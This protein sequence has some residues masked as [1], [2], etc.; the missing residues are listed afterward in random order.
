MQKSISKMISFSLKFKIINFYIYFYNKKKKK[1]KKKCGES[2][3]RLGGFSQYLEY[4]Y[5]AL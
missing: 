4:K 5:Q 1:K 3:K 2:Q